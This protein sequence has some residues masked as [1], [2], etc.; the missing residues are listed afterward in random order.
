MPGPQTKQSRRRVS[1]KTFEAY[2]DR[3]L[4]AP[5]N[6]SPMKVE[7]YRAGFTQA[8]LAKKAGLAVGSI[9]DIEAGKYA[10]RE[11]TQLA[12]AKALKVAKESLWK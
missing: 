10:P 1:K 11:R 9:V 3:V 7:R 2:Q 4:A 5:E 6:F 12:I 8:Q